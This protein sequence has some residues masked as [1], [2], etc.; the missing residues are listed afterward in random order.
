MRQTLRLERTQVGQKLQLAEDW[1]GLE[2]DPLQTPRCL[3][4]GCQGQP[5]ASR[6]YW[7]LSGL[8][9]WKSVEYV[10]TV[11]IDQRSDGADWQMLMFA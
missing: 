7:R 1:Y 5:V 3:I 11:H 10:C 2:P 9:R 6:V 4:F 8:R